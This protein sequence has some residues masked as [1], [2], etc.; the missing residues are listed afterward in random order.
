MASFV[1]TDVSIPAQVERLVQ[2]T[3]DRFGQ[4]DVLVNNAGITRCW[5][6]ALEMSP[7][8]W[9]R[10]I[11]VNLTGVF[12]CA[13]AVA[14]H[15]ARKKYGRIINIGSVASFM[16]QPNAAHYCAAKGGLIMLTKSLALDLSPHNI[17]VNAVAPG[18]IHTERSVEDGVGGLGKIPL[19]RLGTVEELAAAVLFLAS[20]EASYIQGQTLVVDGGWLLT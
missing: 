5:D 20:D 13:Q 3:M 10:V 14:K 12:L 1:P 8:S 17:L 15:M 4:I 16:P 6:P 19:G 7:E 2:E 9:Q 18:A 11:D